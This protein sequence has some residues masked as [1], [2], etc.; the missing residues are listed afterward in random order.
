MAQNAPKWQ[1]LL[2]VSESSIFE[3]K[4]GKKNG[5]D[6]PSSLY[7]HSATQVREDHA[8]GMASSNFIPQVAGFRPFDSQSDALTKLRYIS[9]LCNE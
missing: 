4:I 5:R 3:A 6:E 2:E 1:E 8:A 7:I 9:T